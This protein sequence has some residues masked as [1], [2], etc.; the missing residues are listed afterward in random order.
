MAGVLFAG[1]DG[2]TVYKQAAAKVQEGHPEAAIA[3]L[4]PWIESRPGD[5]RALTIMGMAIAASGK[6]ENANSYF[7]QA[8]RIRPAYAPALKG[9]AMNEM[10]LQRHDAA[11]IHFGQLLSL[12][13][14]DPV[15]HAGLGEIAFTRE[16]FASAL[17]H[18]EQAGSLPR[19]NPRLLLD[20]ARAGIALKQP[21]KAATLLGGMPDEADA[22][23]HFEAGILLASLKSYVPAAHQ[24]ELALAGY[25][26]QYLAGFNLVLARVKSGEYPGAIVEGE[27]L[28]A[29][30]QQKAELYNL[31][32]EAYEKAGDTKRAYDSLRSAT[33]IEPSSEANYIDLI[34]LC[35]DHKNY[36]LASEIAAVGLIRLPTSERIHVQLGVVFAMKEQFEEAQKEFEIAERLT[37]GRSLPYVALAL[38]MMQMNRA[39]DAVQK[40][41]DRVHQSPDDYL[42]LW[43]L[44]EA[45][46]RNGTTQGSPEQKE[47]IAALQR[48][49]QLDPDIS[50]SRELLGKLLY[51]E[52]RLDEAA[53]Q[54]ELAIRLDPGN[55]AAI[56]QL[57]QVYSKKGDTVRAKPLFAKVSKM[58][59]E[60]RENFASRRLQQIIRAD[61]QT[62]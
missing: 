28:I 57:A 23:A 53:S 59:T 38:V 43:Y 2:K 11:Q 52:G 16:D 34:S 13:P 32:A 6:F 47:A 1:D 44:G 49:V 48:S 62:Q 31:L 35:I 19:E 37:P 21:D 10:A 27:K 8:L 39:G 36:D 55:E 7:E 30:G 41:R 17:Q 54:L 20:Y 24:F 18:F 26:D 15:A 25:P 40:L 60:E 4:G 45:L 14:G 51:R 50:Q 12:S 3:L 56:Y 46:N 5:L 9:L 22:Q 33:K 42:A 29:A 58:K 61:S